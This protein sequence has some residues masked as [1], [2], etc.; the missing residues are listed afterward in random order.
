MNPYLWK[1]LKIG[2]RKVKKH[3][4]HPDKEGTTFCGR[5]LP[6][7]WM[8]KNYETPDPETMGWNT[9][10][11]C[12]AGWLKYEKDAMAVCHLRFP[13]KHFS[14]FTEEVV[15][16]VN[17][18]FVLRE[19]DKISRGAF[20]TMLKRS[21]GQHDARMAAVIGETEISSTI[22]IPVDNELL[23]IHE[24][25]LGVCISWGDAINSRWE[26]CKAIY[27]VLT[28]EY[29]KSLYRMQDFRTAYEELMV[30]PE[31]EEE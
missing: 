15:N 7:G 13:E 14:K 18:G 1:K 10:R 16:G 22:K 21:K 9:C 27:T 3:I 4:P 28:N 25:S 23:E 6:T 5:D 8:I 30:E 26:F 2:E 17:V 20:A 12:K 24:Y 29:G 31:E 19:L 11:N